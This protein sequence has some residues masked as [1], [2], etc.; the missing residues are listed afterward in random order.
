MVCRG[1]GL[2]AG[3]HGIMSLLKTLISPLIPNGFTVPS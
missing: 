1:E 3:V 2:I